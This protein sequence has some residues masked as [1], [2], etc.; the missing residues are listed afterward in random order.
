MHCF[1]IPPGIPPGSY[2]LNTG[3]Y[4]PATGTRGEIVTSD[5]AVSNNALRLIG[6]EVAK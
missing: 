2:H 6:L 3:I 4:D 5:T 1:Q